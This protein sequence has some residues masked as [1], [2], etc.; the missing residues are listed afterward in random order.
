MARST[1]KKGIIIL[2]V[3]VVVIAVVLVVLAAVGILGSKSDSCPDCCKDCLFLSTSWNYQYHNKAENVSEY[4]AF[5]ED[6]GRAIKIQI[7]E[8]L[9]G[10]LDWRQHQ[11][12]A[13]SGIVEEAVTDFSKAIPGL[14][15]I[16]LS[17]ELD[18]T[19]KDNETMKIVFGDSG[20]EFAGCGNY[21]GAFFKTKPAEGA[22]QKFLIMMSKDNPTYLPFYLSRDEDDNSLCMFPHSINADGLTWEITV[23]ETSTEWLMIDNSDNNPY[24]PG[25]DE[26]QSCLNA[27]D[28]FAYSGDS[29]THALEKCLGKWKEFYPSSEVTW[30]DNL[31][32]GSL[33]TGQIKEDKDRG[34]SIATHYILSPDV[35][36]WDS[37][38]EKI[39]EITNASTLNNYSNVILPFTTTPT[40]SNDRAAVDMEEQGYYLSEGHYVI[41]FENVKIRSGLPFVKIGPGIGQENLIGYDGYSGMLLS[42]FPYFPEDESCPQ[43]F[44]CAGV[45]FQEATSM[46][47]GTDFGKM[48][49]ETSKQFEKNN[50]Y[51]ESARKVLQQSD[52]KD[53]IETVASPGT[54][55]FHRADLELT[56]AGLKTCYHNILNLRRLGVAAVTC[57][58]CA[59]VVP[60][61]DIQKSLCFRW[62]QLV[63]LMP[64]IIISSEETDLT[65]AL[66]GDDGFTK[67]KEILALR[68]Q[69]N[70][71]LAKP[72]SAI[73]WEDNNIV[74]IG[75]KLCMVVNLEGSSEVDV[76]FPE[77]EWLAPDPTAE[78]EG[79][80][81]KYRSGDSPTTLTF[82]EDITKVIFYKLD[83]IFFLKDKDDNIEV[84]I[85]QP[86]DYY[87]GSDITST[88]TYD[89]HE[90]VIK[91]DI[92]NE[93]VSFKYT[94]A[95]ATIDKDKFKVSKITIFYWI[96]DA[97][98][99]DDNGSGNEQTKATYSLG[100]DKFNV[101]FN[102]GENL[103]TIFEDWNV[104]LAGGPSES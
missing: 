35:V 92:A 47:I 58:I 85:Y 13:Y 101:V 49:E 102:F 70:Y 89:G 7:S 1:K 36:I 25:C 14:D 79:T 37:I 54:T 68:K 59:G 17:V 4:R 87:Y 94:A 64:Y 46:C 48:T 2:V 96:K 33:T 28:F 56:E 91:L 65:D 72:G 83:N 15:D 52:V 42:G 11:H 10:V 66:A 51:Y 32:V 74:A 63:L 86:K 31:I 29:V 69:L 57:N 78:T 71:Y 3:L 39:L 43:Y 41:D 104:S 67:L 80:Y 95:V 77:G 18:M 19:K 50:L 44:K 34:D 26:Y 61:T 9:V 12:E 99:D 98:S 5:V 22:S 97:G 103:K 60:S 27:V 16:V 30:T 73:L 81:L 45:Q 21:D 40:I 88:F 23:T 76:K 93:I 84:K 8:N 20:T 53:I 38:L 82:E 62:S 55:H 90:T 100:N 24:E 6:C 75:D